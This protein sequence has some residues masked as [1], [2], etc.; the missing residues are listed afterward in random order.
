MLFST[1]PPHRPHPL[2]AR[3][4]LPAASRK[5]HVHADTVPTASRKRHLHARPP[6]ARCQQQDRA[7]ANTEPTAGKNDAFTLTRRQHGACSKSEATNG[8]VRETGNY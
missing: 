3:G 1:V 5:R 8:S 6:A 2:T 4:T 7:G